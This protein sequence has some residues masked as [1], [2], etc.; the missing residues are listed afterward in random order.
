[1][2]ETFITGVN[3]VTMDDFTSGFNIGTNYT[4]SYQFNEMTGF[5]EEEVRD[6]LTYYTDSCNIHNHTVDELI[7]IMKPW[8]ANYC[9]SE[10]AYGETT[11]Y[12]SNMVLYFVDNYINS[13]GKIPTN[14]V[15][16]NI[17]A[18]YNKLRMLIRRDKELTPEASVIQNLVN[19]GQV[20]DDLATGF[21]EE[22]ICNHEYFLSLLYYTGLVTIAG[23]YHGRLVFKI[24]NKAM[25]DVLDYLMSENND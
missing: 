19:N 17:R 23:K 5:T 3:P 8:Y 20:C 9:F 1:M 2:E 16:E 6:M 25:Q 22:K 14:M 4:L 13:N 11:I 21:S 7:E 18:D 24:P 10:P 12:N 15:E